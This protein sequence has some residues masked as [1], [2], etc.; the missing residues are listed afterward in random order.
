M[1]LAT[2][3]IIVLLFAQTGAASGDSGWA[4]PDS[5]FYP[6]KIWMEKFSLNFVFNQ[7]EK[8][9]GML[10]LAEERLREAESMGNSSKAYERAMDEYVG[11]LEELHSIITK[12][13]LNESKEIRVDIKEKIGDHVN[14]TK[15]INGNVSIIQHN[16]IEASSSS[17]ESKIKV[18]V[19]DG[20]VSV[21]TEGGN[22]VIT[23]D[24][25]NVTVVSETNNSSQQ[26][27]VRSSGNASSS[28]SVIVHSSSKV[29]SGN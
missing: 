22:P 5:F 18:S 26:V 3:T 10:D 24:G 8:T 12:D 4:G 2:I 27:I 17:G 25:S 9:R 7:T 23:R 1:R 19:D 6:V 16:L 20:N 13:T 14:R 15:S 11:Q 29:V 28:S 21:E